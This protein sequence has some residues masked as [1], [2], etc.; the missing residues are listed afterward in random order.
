MRNKDIEQI[1]RDAVLR[2][3]TVDAEGAAHRAI[4]DWY[5]SDKREAA[6][7]QRMLSHLAGSLAHYGLDTEVVSEFQKATIFGTN[8]L[9]DAPADAD[10]QN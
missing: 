3:N 7:L 4:V 8:P 5:S 6:R 1:L 10:K 9:L 2:S